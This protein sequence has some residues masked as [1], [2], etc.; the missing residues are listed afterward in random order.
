MGPDCTINTFPPE[1]NGNHFEEDIFKCNSLMEVHGI[2]LHIHGKL[3]HIAGMHSG[4]MLGHVVRPHKTL[5]TYTTVVG[6]LFQMHCVSMFSKVL[7][8]LEAFATSLTDKWTWL[9]KRNALN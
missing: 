1:Q 2:I 3:F 4:H 6:F 8:K 7:L 9:K 5:A